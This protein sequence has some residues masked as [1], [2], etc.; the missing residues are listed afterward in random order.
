MTDFLLVRHGE[1]VWHAENRYAGRTDVPLTD[2]GREQARSLAQW[3]ATADLTAVWSS[4][5][6]RARLTAAPAA[7]A[8]GLPLHVDERLYELDFGQGEG[9]TRDE[10]RQRF[11][12]HVAAFLADP[13][14]HHLPGGE[15][16]RHAAERAAACLADIARDQPHGRVLVVAHSTLVR[17]LLCHLLGIPL[18]AY[19]RVLPQLHNAALTEIRMTDDTTALLRLN[20]PALAAAPALP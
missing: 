2:R 18:G 10:M 20:A 15:H 9:L 14:D 5:L 11:P 1:T 16:P 17:V 4:P 12:Q 19:R 13:A 3:A 6:S 7:D 8:C